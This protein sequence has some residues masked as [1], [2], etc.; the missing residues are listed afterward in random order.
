MMTDM[1]MVNNLL[2]RKNLKLFVSGLFTLETVRVVVA[3]P[4]IV[5]PLKEPSDRAP[6][7][8]AYHRYD[9]SPVP[10]AEFAGICVGNVAVAIPTNVA[11]D[12]G[13]VVRPTGCVT[14]PKI[15]PFSSK[16]VCFILLCFS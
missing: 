4:E 12:D 5:A 3:V 14:T 16:V 2:V 13:V 7:P 15:G 11:V 9:M 6:T 1:Q 10:V 8:S